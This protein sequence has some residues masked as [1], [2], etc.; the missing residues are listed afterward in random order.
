MTIG[1]PIKIKIIR[2]RPEVDQFSP[3]GKVGRPGYIE[4][5]HEEYEAIRLS[6]HVGLSQSDSAKFMGISQQT[7]SRI[8]R[9]GRKSLATGLITGKIIRIKGGEFKF[10]KSAYRA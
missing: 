8:I 2:K 9:K 3:R 6:D 1:R 4:L 7:F 5:K 10:E